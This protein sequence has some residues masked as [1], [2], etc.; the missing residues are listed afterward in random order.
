M[1]CAKLHNYCIEMNEGS[2]KDIEQRLDSD[3]V[4]GDEHTVDENANEGADVPYPVGDR[5]RKMTDALARDGIKRRR[6]TLETYDN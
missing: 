4:T 6:R 2:E 5:R 3:H 1:V